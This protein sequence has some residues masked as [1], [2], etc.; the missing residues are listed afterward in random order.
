M[1]IDFSDND[2]VWIDPGSD[3]G[4]PWDL[5]RTLTDTDGGPVFIEKGH[6]TADNFYILFDAGERVRLTMSASS[7]AYRWLDPRAEVPVCSG[8]VT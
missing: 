7:V 5:C 4:S 1:D 2:M 3:Y 8:F 6:A